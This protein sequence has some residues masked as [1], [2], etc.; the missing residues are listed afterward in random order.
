LK[1][2]E[3]RKERQ[4]SGK[5]GAESRWEKAQAAQSV[6]AEGLNLDSS[7]NSS[8]IAKLLQEPL[9]L[10]A[11]SS[12]SSSSSSNKADT[13]VSAG[14]NAPAPARKKA[15]RK[16]TTCDEEFLE[17]L[18]RNPAYAHLNV[19]AH[20]HRMVAWCQ[21]KG[22]QPSRSRFIGWLNREDPPPA[23]SPVKANGAADEWANREI[24]ATVE[25]LPPTY[26]RIAL[27]AS[28]EEQKA[29]VLANY[30]RRV[31]QARGEVTA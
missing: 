2:I 11:S 21:N 7:A 19:K 22:K 16:P 9:A 25:D 24:A 30:N 31:R 15:T 26:R 4:E 13:N 17:E 27:D 8:A 10:D 14:A 5:K 3:H 6:P 12:S 28:T 1:Q 29:N 18:Q 20:Y 23:Q